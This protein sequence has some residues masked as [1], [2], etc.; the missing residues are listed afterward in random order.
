MILFEASLLDLPVSRL[1]SLLLSGVPW[2]WV[3]LGVFAGVELLVL[4][5]RDLPRVRPVLRRFE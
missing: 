1:T 5:A 3:C 2:V 4:A